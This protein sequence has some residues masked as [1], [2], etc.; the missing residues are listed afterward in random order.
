MFFNAGCNEQVL[1]S[2]PGKKAQIQLVV[3]R[4]TQKSLTTT[5]SNSEKIK[6]LS[7]RLRLL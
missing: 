6:S 4:K 3:S 7:R 5:H 2:K 1:S